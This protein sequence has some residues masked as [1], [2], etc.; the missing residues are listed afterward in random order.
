MANVNKAYI[1]SDEAGCYHNNLLIASLKDIGNCIGICV[2]NYY[3]SEP[4]Q[5]KNNC[6]RTILKKQG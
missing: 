2:Q 4:Q 1:R 3:F 6:E 5:G